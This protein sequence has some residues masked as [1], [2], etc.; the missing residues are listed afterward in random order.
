MIVRIGPS[1]SGRRRCATGVRC[2]DALFGSRH[3]GCRAS[4]ADLARYIAGVTPRAPD[5]FLHTKIAPAA[6]SPSGVVRLIH[7]TEESHLRAIVGPHLARD[8]NGLLEWFLNSEVGRP[9]GDPNRGRPIWMPLTD[10]DAALCAWVAAWVRTEYPA[11][12]W[13]PMFVLR[14]GELVAEVAAEPEMI[15]QAFADASVQV[16]SR[17]RARWD[18]EIAP[19]YPDACAV[20]AA[21][22]AGADPT[23]ESTAYDDAKALIEAARA[24]ADGVRD[25]GGQHVRLFEQVGPAL[26]ATEAAVRA[27]AEDLVQG[28]YMEIDYHR[29]DAAGDDWC[30]RQMA[31][32]RDV[33]RECASP[34]AE[35]T[36]HW[37]TRAAELSGDMAFA[38]KLMAS[39]PAERT[40]LD[41]LLRSYADGDKP[42]ELVYGLMC[43]VMNDGVAATLAGEAACRLPGAATRDRARA[44]H[45][46]HLLFL[47][48]Q[49]LDLW[50]QRVGRL[51]TPDDGR[52]Q[53][54]L[55]AVYAA[56]QDAVHDHVVSVC[57]PDD[58]DAFAAEYAAREVFRG[59]SV[60]L[61]IERGALDRVTPCLVGTIGAEIDGRFRSASA[62]FVPDARSGGHFDRTHVAV[63]RP[64]SDD[65]AREL[66]CRVGG[67][68][69]AYV[70]GETPV[71]P[72]GSVL[73][74]WE[75]ARPETPAVC[76]DV[77]ELLGVAPC[78]HVG[79]RWR[80]NEPGSCEWQPD[81]TSVFD[82]R[83]WYCPECDARDVVAL[84]RIEGEVIPEPEAYL[85]REAFHRLVRGGQPIE[86]LAE[87][88]EC[89]GVVTLTR[90]GALDH[91][92]MLSPDDAPPGRDLASALFG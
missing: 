5:S 42:G 92:H 89:D 38:R 53:A 24:V 81:G 47:D 12:E 18:E 48:N 43:Q 69:A 8:G 34:S 4:E 87:L 63:L 10:L 29:A 66:L 74:R 11:Q 19:F 64:R 78:A 31:I 17:Q 22:D 65:E 70:T 84:H 50:R 15:R 23:A 68:C 6:P 36:L 46:T 90:Y 56:H 20:V 7:G 26:R 59:W 14:L 32:Y 28:R 13:G 45:R 79:A 40:A 41:A 88:R 57:S 85:R 35:G 16:V 1:S 30:P 76:R 55:P 60:H 80:P 9:V 3:L 58:L 33:M 25:M 37:I 91:R 49:P 51:L 86:S 62:V 61:E 44:E 77:A 67:P 39:G 52:E 54:L 82:A 27:A 2:A 72:L 73:D 75:V 71:R 83:E 21:D